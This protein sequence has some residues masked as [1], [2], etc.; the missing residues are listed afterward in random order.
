MGSPNTC[1]CVK[2]ELE[3]SNGL[4]KEGPEGQTPG[5][6]EEVVGLP[7]PRQEGNRESR[8]LC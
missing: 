5:W 1:V 3:I 8:L 7:S 4:R 6:K 2:Y